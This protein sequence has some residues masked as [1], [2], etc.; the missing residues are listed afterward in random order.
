MRPEN[1]LAWSLN[2]EYGHPPPSQPPFDQFGN[3]VVDITANIKEWKREFQAQQ[4]E[5]KTQERGFRQQNSNGPK[6]GSSKE[7]VEAYIKEWKHANIRQQREADERERISR[8][9]DANIP[10]TQ[11]RPFAP[12]VEAH[13][14]QVRKQQADQEEHDRMRKILFPNVFANAVPKED[15][16]PEPKL[17]KI[18]QVQR[19]PVP[20]SNDDTAPNP[21]REKP[22]PK[23]N[24]DTTT[25]TPRP[26]PPQLVLLRNGKTKRIERM[27]SYTE[28]VRNMGYPEILCPLPMKEIDC[29]GAKVIKRKEG[30]QFCE[31]DREL[32]TE[33]LG[34][35]DGDGSQGLG[36]Q[37]LVG[38]G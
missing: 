3:P 11:T 7:D 27:G 36:T 13:W 14:K 18:P 37:A 21:S 20:K 5:K 10:K 9:Q 32:D 30:R 29:T 6:I 1:I 16:K 17:F 28:R 23:P 22:V 12:D 15:T 19:K 2:V 4:A 38:G 26:P 31:K 33:G 35:S 24:D 34:L 25:T 8:Q